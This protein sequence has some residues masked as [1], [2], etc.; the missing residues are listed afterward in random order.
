MCDV[1]RDG[2]MCMCM[3]GPLGRI[4]PMRLIRLE[5][6]EKQSGAHSRKTA[7]EALGGGRAGVSSAERIRDEGTAR[8][9]S[10]REGPGRWIAYVHRE[11]VC[12][13][14]EATGCA[15]QMLPD[16]ICATRLSVMYR[17]MCRR[18]APQGCAEVRRLSGA[19]RVCVGLWVRISREWRL[20]KTQLSGWR[21]ESPHC[22]PSSS[23][24]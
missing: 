2:H 8:P 17:G 10:L 16:T 5:C 15:S 11:D 13:L 1:A 9:G 22:P 19:S 23:K 14:M 18:V 12:I 3:L 24:L 21:A 4:T 6:P 7:D 20:W